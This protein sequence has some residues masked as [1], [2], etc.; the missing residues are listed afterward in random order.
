MLT[1]LLGNPWALL[2]GAVLAFAAGFALQG[3]LKDGEIARLNLGHVQALAQAQQ[4]KSDADER[5]RLAEQAT[6]KSIDTLATDFTERQ[7]HEKTATDQRIA[8]L[9][10]ERQRLRIALARPASG[11]ALSCPA[12]PAGGGDGETYA[13]ARGDVSARLER[14]YADYNALVDQ[15]DLLQ[16]TIDTYRKMAPTE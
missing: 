1:K 3:E 16:A 15:I 10:S 2:A 8:D 7:A 5:A 9:L 14:R 6:Q 13:F 12:S 11:G 4:A